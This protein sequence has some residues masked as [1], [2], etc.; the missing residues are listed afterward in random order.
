M[1]SPGGRALVALLAGWLFAGG[2]GDA[3]AQGRG[4]CNGGRAGSQAMLSTAA[5]AYGQQPTTGLTALRGQQNPALLAAYLQQRQNAT[6][7][8]MQQQQAL[9]AAALQQGD[10]QVAEALQQQAAQLA[11]LLQ[12]QNLQL[13]A[14]QAQ[15][16]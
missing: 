12:Q 1:R 9:L 3:R 16:R 15:G 10:P 11:A 5:R 6:L 14:L 13:R 4:N 7:Q 2:A 8:A